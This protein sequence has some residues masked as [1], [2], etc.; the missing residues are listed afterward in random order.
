VRIH[1]YVANKFCPFT[2][3][4]IMSK[5]RNRKLFLEE[6]T[7]HLVCGLLFDIFRIFLYES[8]KNQNLKSLFCKI[9]NEK[10]CKIGITTNIYTRKHSRSNSWK[11]KCI[12]KCVSYINCMILLL[13]QNDTK[14]RHEKQNS[15]HT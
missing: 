4:F 5:I 1:L 8:D 15:W 9:P 3:D 2:F 10:L 7:L 12:I 11:L 14:V 13:T 6:I